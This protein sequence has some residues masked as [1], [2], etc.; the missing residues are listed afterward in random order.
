MTPDYASFVASRSK[1]GSA[2]IADLTPEKAHLL[3]MAVGITGE[4]GELA[5]AIKKHVIYGKPLDVDNV[6]EEVGDALFMLQAILNVAKPGMTIE[7]V[8]EMNRVKLITRYPTGYSDAAA[9]A[10]AD[11]AGH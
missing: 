10:R 1:P 4:A 9:Q 5:D 6:V 11:K 2:I 7:E 8:A 3:H